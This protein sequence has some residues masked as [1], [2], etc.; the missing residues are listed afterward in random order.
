MLP[1][2]AL[3]SNGHIDLSYTELIKFKTLHSEN[4]IQGYSLDDT[5]SI[6]FKVTELNSQS[7]CVLVDD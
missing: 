4:L 2:E 6:P 3:L 5:V 1:G 7:A